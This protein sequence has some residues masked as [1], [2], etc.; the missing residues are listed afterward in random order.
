[1]R[2]FTL[3]SGLRQWIYDAKAPLFA[4]P[5]VAGSVVVVADLAG[6]VHALDLKTGKPLWTLDLGR[7]ADVAAPGM[8]YGGPVVH[9]GRI[10]VATCN[11][12]GPHARKPTVVVCLGAK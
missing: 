4:A 11:L 10:Y 2:S 3:T 1:V 5:A 9:G 8:V 6:V 12:D 7:S